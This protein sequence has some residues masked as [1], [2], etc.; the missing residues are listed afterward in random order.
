MKKIALIPARS[1]SKRIKDKNIK[2]LG[3][4]PLI[5]HTI[6]YC[7]RLN[8]F[9]KILVSTDSEFYAKIVESSGSAKPIIRPE[10]ISTD[11]SPDIEWINDLGEKGHFGIDDVLFL[12]R[13]TSPFRS[14]EFLRSAW[15]KFKNSGRN[16]DSLRAITPVDVHPGKMWTI[17]GDDMSPLFPF[18]LDGV[19]WHSNQLKKLPEVYRQTA[20]LEIIWSKTIIQKRS[21][22]GNHILPFICH[23]KDAFDINEEID[24]QIA[25]LILSQSTG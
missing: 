13:P 3:T 11:T 9:D 24:F 5:Q 10:S 17:I 2:T 20:S 4:K 18:L 14:E 21:I 16:Y 23:D 1:G 15:Q 12:L 22:S 25:E 19:P 6:D 7:A 8:L